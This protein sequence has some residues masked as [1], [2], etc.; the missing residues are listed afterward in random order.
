MPFDLNELNPSVRFNYPDEN[1]REWVDFRLVD[2]T[3]R[4]RINKELGIEFKQILKANPL[5]KKMEWVFDNDSLT[6]EQSK[7]LGNETLNY[8][9]SNWNLITNTG[10]KIEC[11]KENKLKLVYG[12]PV[13]S[14]WVNQCL[15]S[16]EKVIVDAEE[17]LEKN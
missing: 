9:I 4:E 3:E 5:T 6:R 1:G 17:E 10:E 13:F 14:K 15:K 16:I 7:A 11:N 8:Q 12:S 2:D